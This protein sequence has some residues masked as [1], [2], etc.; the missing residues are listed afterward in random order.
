[1]KHC[2]FC[3][4][5]IKEK[6]IK[7]KHCYSM[8]TDEKSVKKVELDTTYDYFA[9]A[10]SSF[11][12]G[13]IMYYI[14]AQFETTR[15]FY[16][17]SR[18]TCDNISELPLASFLCHIGIYFGL[19]KWFFTFAFCSSVFGKVIFKENFFLLLGVQVLIFTSFKLLFI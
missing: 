6:A 10:L 19:L 4:E 7:C 17:I 15:I 9:F 16:E 14:L 1:M 5:E 8:L 3:F 12:L 13:F 2:P 11:V 18:D